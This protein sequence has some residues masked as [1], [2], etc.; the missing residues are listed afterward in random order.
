M[1]KASFASLS[2]CVSLLTASAIAGENNAYDDPR[3][4]E[5]VDRICFARSID[6]FS[7][8]DDY[9]DAVLLKKGVS[10]WFFVE[11]RGSCTTRSLRF[12]QAVGVD[13]FGGGGCLTRGDTLVFSDTVFKPKPHDLT[14]CFVDDMYKW[15]EECGR[16][17][18]I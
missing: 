18:G 14:R 6:S 17:R 5:E 1:K 12:A 16:G 15:D 3:I 13:T 8:P 9:D 4:G 7:I 10:K 2:V 11:L